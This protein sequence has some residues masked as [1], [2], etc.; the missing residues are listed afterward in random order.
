MAV[1]N[2]QDLHLRGIKW[3]LTNDS[4]LSTTFPIELILDTVGDIC[5]L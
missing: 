3:W 4:I 2:P 5:S 1:V